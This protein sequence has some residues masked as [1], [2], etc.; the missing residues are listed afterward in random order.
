M[1]VVS[2]DGSGLGALRGIGESAEPSSG[3]YCV[4]R[5][6]REPAPGMTYDLCMDATPG[7]QQSMTLGLG[8]LLL[9]LPR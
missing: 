3:N 7:T 4:V 1:G 9:G 8:A 6:R 5:F 2:P